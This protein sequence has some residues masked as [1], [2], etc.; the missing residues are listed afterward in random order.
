MKNVKTGEINKNKNMK[1]IIS[2]THAPAA[3]GPYSQGIQVGDLLFV[4]GQIPIVPETGKILEGDIK[5]QTLQVM[6]NIGAV[7]EAAGM[8]YSNLVKCTCYLADI[9]DFK[10]MN[11]VYGTY[12]SAAPPARAAIQVGKLPLGS[13]VEID[14]IAAKK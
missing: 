9:E 14:A 8:D 4:S 12:F 6:K 3:I 7:L 2:T 13:K 5:M 11:E 10:A 1:K